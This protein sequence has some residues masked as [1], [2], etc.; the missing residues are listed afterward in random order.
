MNFIKALTIASAVAISSLTAQ[1]EVKAPAPKTSTA[2][3]YDTRFSLGLGAWQG[4]FAQEGYGRTVSLTSSKSLGYTGSIGVSGGA[5]APIFL[6]VAGSYF[7]AK[8]DSG[9]SAEA[10]YVG[11][12][13]NLGFSHPSFPLEAY[14]GIEFGSYKFNSGFD[15]KF[16]TMGYLLGLGFMMRTSARFGLG[17]KGEY[18]W[19]TSTKDD[20][21]DL[22]KEY[23]TAMQIPYVG[24][25]ALIIF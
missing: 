14:G 18:R 11:Y 16:N 17:I 20:S 4:T 22:P 24:L 2:K 8:E 13:A 10:R 7:G 21:G 1:A 6:E 15:T 25:Y 5:S 23:K 9:D 19:I 12:G 3:F